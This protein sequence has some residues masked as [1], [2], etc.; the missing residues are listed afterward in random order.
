MKTSGFREI[1]M[2]KEDCQ[3]CKG[4]VYVSVFIGNGS[5]G[6]YMHQKCGN[7]ENGIVNVAELQE[8]ELENG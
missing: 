7:C 6:Y 2:T 8:L 1:D 5:S 3:V 4:F